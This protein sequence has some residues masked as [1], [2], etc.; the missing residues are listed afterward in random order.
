MTAPLVGR[1]DV[2]GRIARLR[3]AAGHGDLSL[4]VLEGE[5]GIGKTAVAEAARREAAAAGW[6]TGWVQGVEGDA[7]LPYAG[8]LSLVRPLRADLTALVE[9]QQA[10][11]TAALGWSAEPV[12]GDRFQVAA[13]TL[14]L[15][16]QA[17]ERAPLLIVVDDVGWLDAESAE[18]LVFAARR[19]R[20]DRVAFVLTRRLGHTDPVDLTGV[21]IERLSG[22]SVDAVR[23]LLGPGYSDAVVEVMARET[24]GNPLAL[25]ESARSLTPLQR[26]GA[27]ELPA[28]LPVPERLSR[29]FTAELTR[30]SPGASLAVRLAAA[31]H[32]R[33]MR[34][35][36]AALRAAGF[37]PESCLDEA[38]PVLSS[39]GGQLAFR[40]PLVRSVAWEAASAAERRDAHAALADVLP[41]GP[42]RTW[43]RAAAAT[44]HQPALAAD[45]AAS[46][47]QARARRGYAGASAA[48]E[49]A[50]RLVGDPAVALE[51]LAAAVDD[52]FLAG[53]GTRARRLAE[54][55]LAGATDPS[56]RATV[57]FVLG[58]LEEH[59]GTFPRAKALLEEAAEIATGPL[60]IRALTEVAGVC[61]LLDDPAGVA[62]AAAAARR[63]ADPADPEQVMLAAYLSGAAAVFAG[64]LAE[65]ADE[66]VRALDLLEGQPSLR[67]DPRYLTLVPLCARWLL[68]PH[69]RVGGLSLVQIATRRV[70]VARERGALG[71]LAVT[72]S[73]MAAGLAWT[74][75]HLRAYA[76]AGEAVELLDTLGYTVEPG[77]AHETLAVESAARG[78]FAESDDLLRRAED[79]L[80]H[81]GFAT[82]QP[83][84]AH[85]MISCAESRGDLARVVVLGEDL[86]R[87]HEG[88]GV[89][90]EPL[91]VTP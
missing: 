51:Y 1:T 40:H 83:H 5:A 50:A 45:L 21:E 49:Q 60:R 58:M 10:A 63:D 2:L 43:H 8:L 82:V 73:L 3:S 57:L 75:D 39:V 72:L 71:P 59:T 52:A 81:T 90:L 37:T 67:D 88:A 66:T 53:D 79:I 36:T 77:V 55:V 35:M 4:L 65:G 86:L 74:G 11:L 62:A 6:Q 28:A 42:A 85:A 19:L 29:I 20:Y 31:S 32:D 22:L 47:E 61:Y 89:L 68:N 27:E 14:A 12:P 30:L 34:A 78:R 9:P 13:A 24:A 17:A 16:G 64:R 76:F 70:A 23:A 46:A 41:D 91:G 80:R 84:L 33:E 38:S 7:A 69:H 18:A 15:L 87:R 56:P 26:V 54:S 25:L 48:Y 44:G